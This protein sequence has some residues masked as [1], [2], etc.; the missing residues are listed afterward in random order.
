MAM[1]SV[2]RVQPIQRPAKPRYHSQ[3]DDKNQ[4]NDSFHALSGWHPAALPNLQTSPPV[5]VRRES[6]LIDISI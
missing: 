6:R 2:Q 1:N 4:A 5:L 3:A